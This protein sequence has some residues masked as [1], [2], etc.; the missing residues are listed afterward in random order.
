MERGAKFGE[1]LVDVRFARCGEGCSDKFSYAGLGMGW[2]SGNVS[3]KRESG[4]YG[5]T[6]KDLLGAPR[7]SRRVEISVGLCGTLPI[8]LHCGT[9]CQ[10]T[11]SS[12]C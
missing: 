7:S 11:T 3:N 2:H 8:H 1:N 10:A 12:A 6:L 5:K 4:P 9:S